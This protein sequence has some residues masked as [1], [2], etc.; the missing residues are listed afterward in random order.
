MEFSPSRRPVTDPE[1]VEGERSSR[2]KYDRLKK[3]T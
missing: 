2:N 3:T 1:L